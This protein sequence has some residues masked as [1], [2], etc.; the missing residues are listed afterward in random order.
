M[1][2]KESLLLLETCEQGLRKLLADAAGTGD[3][4]AV[5][6][7]ADLAKAVAALAAE[8]HSAQPTIT[9]ASVTPP[10]I[11]SARPGGQ[12]G[13][14]TAGERRSRSSSDTYPKFFRRGDELV[15][16]GWSKNDRKEYNHRAPRG[17]VD[18]VAAAI[19]Q[20]G[21]KGRLFT[22]DEMLPLKDLT[23]GKSIPDYQ[24][25]VALAWLKDLGVVEQHGRRAGYSLVEEAPISGTIA[26]SWPELAGWHG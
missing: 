10:K 20:I 19:K 21:A 12:M 24:A 17:V 25:Y 13:M 8:G 15:K 22:G 2:W 3:Y 18:A 16:V 11:G 5:S 4:V 14:P 9:A 6:R 1:K 23:R 26:A 7:I